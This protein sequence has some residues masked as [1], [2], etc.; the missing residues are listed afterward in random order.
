MNNFIYVDF[1]THVSIW[2]L[3]SMKFCTTR[4]INKKSGSTNVSN[5]IQAKKHFLIAPQNQ[6]SF[7]WKQISLASQVIYNGDKLH[8]VF[9]GIFYK[10]LFDLNVLKIY[11]FPSRSKPWNWMVLYD[12]L[13]VSFN[14]ESLGSITVLYIHYNVPCFI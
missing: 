5:N 13:H 3:I 14:Q 4:I 11:F 1:Q 10:T 6:T 7:Q 2:F 8:V 9:I 12:E